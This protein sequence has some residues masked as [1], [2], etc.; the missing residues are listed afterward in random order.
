MKIFNVYHSIDYM[1]GYL[2]EGFKEVREKV[3]K[4]L[5]TDANNKY[6]PG[7]LRF[8]KGG[9]CWKEFKRYFYIDE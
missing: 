7:T 3:Q 6:L 4:A 2:F 5:E 1:V 9:K 8:Y